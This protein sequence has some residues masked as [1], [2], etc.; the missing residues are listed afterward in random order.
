MNLA[1]F[2]VI[3]AVTAAIWRLLKGRRVYCMR[4]KR[5]IYS[6]VCWSTKYNGAKQACC[7]MWQCPNHPERLRWL[8]GKEKTESICR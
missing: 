7:L 5:N 4:E 3:V 1:I 2:V 6:H 8:Y